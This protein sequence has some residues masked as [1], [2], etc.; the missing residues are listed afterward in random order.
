M[1]ASGTAASFAI[2]LHG[3]AGVI[4]RKCVND[5]V[6]YLRELGAI[7]A[8]ARDLALSGTATAADVAERA[9]ALLEDCELFN[10]GKGA[11][12]THEGTH[13]ME[14]SI[15]DGRTGRAGC[16]SMLS[17]PRH[18]ISVARLVMN[19]TSHV[20]LAGPSAEALAAR[21]GLEIMKP[22]WFDTNAR[23]AQ[24]EHAIKECR[25]V[26][27]HCTYAAEELKSYPLHSDVLSG[28]GA[29]LPRLAEASAEGVIAKDSYGGGGNT[30]GC[31][32][33]LGGDV[34]AATSTGG[35][36][37]KMSGRIGDSPIIGAGTFAR[38]STCAVSGTG[39]GEDFQRQCVAHDISALMEY[40]G[41]D[42]ESACKTAVSKLPDNCGGVIAVDAIGHLVMVFNSKGM[43]RA[44]C[45]SDGLCCVGIWHQLWQY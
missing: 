25:V 26:Q 32:V 38:N 23:R 4:S 31:V 10:A 34:A 9:V 39:N 15:M 45:N 27:D 21:E 43:F 37:N 40:K 36:T 18:P 30:V 16:S 20:L 33:M 35:R 3:G 19:K 28:S 41:L 11:V 24:L 2:A 1:A 13:E 44:A 6:R 14:A 12:F 22:S 42:V 17:T 7:V 29:D 8:A 5:P